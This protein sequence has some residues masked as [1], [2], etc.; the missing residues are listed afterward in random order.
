MTNTTN[1][2]PNIDELLRSSAPA[3]PKASTAQLVAL[4]RAAAE[5]ERAPRL[6]RRLLVFVPLAT[7]GAL[8][9]TAGAVAV[10]TIT[11][12]VTVPLSYTTDTGSVLS[13]TAEFAAGSVFD[14]DDRALTDYLRGY[15]WNGFGQDVYNRALAEPFDPATTDL[16][17]LSQSEIDSMSWNDAM[18]AE[19]SDAIPQS[20]LGQDAAYFSWSSDCEGLLH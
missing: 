11:A 9:L 7:V 18:T 8:A 3:A 1:L 4:S 5:R 15:N 10:S 20:L 17:D 12:D 2:P 19:L 14:A 13:C 16:V 6:K